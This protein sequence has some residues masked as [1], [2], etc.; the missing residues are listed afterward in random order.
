M[1]PGKFLLPTAG[2]A[3]FSKRKF[4]TIYKARNLD[5]VPFFLFR[6]FLFLGMTD[7]EVLMKIVTSNLAPMEAIS[8]CAGP[9]TSGAEQKI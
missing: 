9:E 7:D 4:I 3:D 1:N 6:Y 8:F 2:T 5:F